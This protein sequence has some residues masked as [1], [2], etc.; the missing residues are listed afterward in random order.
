MNEFDVCKK[1]WDDLAQN[2][3]WAV[4][5]DKDKAGGGWDHEQFFETGKREV[6]VLFDYLQTLGLRPGLK[7]VALDF[8]CG[9]GR[10]KMLC[11]QMR[12][13]SRGGHFGKN[14]R[15]GEPIEPRGGRC[16]FHLNTT[17]DLVQVSTE[18]FDFIYSSIVLQHIPVHY[19]V[20]YLQEFVHYFDRMVFSSF[21]CRKNSNRRMRG[22]RSLGEKFG[23]PSS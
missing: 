18:S 23:L 1:T 9:V 14:D 15:S 5:T 21:K 22:K 2:H 13:S 12:R 11:R 4:L 19:V 7:A 10:L 6:G 20:R 16:Q 3:P 8:G 17:P